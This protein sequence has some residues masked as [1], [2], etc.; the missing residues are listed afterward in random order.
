MNLELLDKVISWEGL[1]LIRTRPKIGNDRSSFDKTHIIWTISALFDAF[2]GLE[3]LVCHEI[4]YLSYRQVSYSSVCLSD[5]VI[6]YVKWIFRVFDRFT[7]Q[8]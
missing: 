1:K 4:K 7:K 6:F 5:H 8:Y 2:G 3:C